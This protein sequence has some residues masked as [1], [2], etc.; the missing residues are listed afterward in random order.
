M[1][2]MQLLDLFAQADIDGGLVGG[3]FPETRFRKDRKLQII[4]KY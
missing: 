2:E 4:I 3:A 1:Q